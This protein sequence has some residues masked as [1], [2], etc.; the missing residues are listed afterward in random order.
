MPLPSWPE[1][2]NRM[3]CSPMVGGFHSRSAPARTAI[4]GSQPV[5][6]DPVLTCARGGFIWTSAMVQR[7]MRF[8]SGGRGWLNRSWRRWWRHVCGSAAYE[9]CRIS[10]YKT[11]IVIPTS[12]SP[13][14]RAFGAF[15]KDTK[16]LDIVPDYSVWGNKR[17][18]G[19]NQFSDI[20]CLR[21]SAQARKNFQFF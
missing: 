4:H 9:L 6:S 20:R 3:T 16:N 5:V 19:Q 14:F 10:I 8:R 15:V 13:V 11:R 7:R 17:V 2:L 12:R 21:R 18:F 1:G